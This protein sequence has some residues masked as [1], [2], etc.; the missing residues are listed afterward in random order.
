M[1]WQGGRRSGNVEDRRGMGPVAV[2]GGG[3]GALVLALIGYFVFGDPNALSG[4][5]QAAPA[6]QQEGV[7][8]SPQDEQAA[9][10]DTILASTE[11]VWSAEFAKVGKHYDPTRLVLYEE[12]TTTACG[13]GQSAMG[14]FYCPRDRKVYLDLAFFREL[15][16][17]FGA[18]GDF[19]QAYVLAHEV[20]HHVQNQLGISDEVSRAQQAAGS[21]AQANQYSVAL[22]LQAD[23][24]AGIWAAKSQQAHNWLESGDVEEGLAAA[25][26]VG[27]DT[28]QKRSRGYVVPDSF[29]HGTSEQR[30]RWFMTGFKSGDPNACDPFG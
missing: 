24:Y 17:R 29:T 14:P 28:L 8:G 16:Q 19:A 30:M 21:E 18:P 6:E 5:E 1:R 12:G 22:E 3:I 4:L 11:D 7:V 13:V 2:A 9:F 23:C 10:M 26:A 25:S 20:G 15:D 27:D